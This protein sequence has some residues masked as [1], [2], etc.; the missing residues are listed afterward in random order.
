MKKNKLKIIISILCCATVFLGGVSTPLPGVSADNTK[1]LSLQQAQTMAQARSTAYKKIQNKIEMQQVKYTAAVKSIQMK[2][3]NMRTFRWTPLLSFKFPEQPHLVDEYEWQYK[4][5]QITCEIDRLRHS[6]QDTKLSVKETVSILYVDVYICQQ[7]I[8]FIENR[9]ENL[10]TTLKR[11]KARLAL[12][13]ATQSDIDKMT[14]SLDKLN[15]DLSLQMRTF[16]VKKTKLSKLIGTDVS[17]GYQFSAPFLD[18]DIPRTALQT[19]TD[20]TLERDQDYYEA[21]LNEQLALTSLN[22][23]EGFMYNQYGSKMYQIQGYINQARAGQE[24][25]G[26]A[27]KRQYNN[28]LNDVDSPWN[29]GIR[30]LF[31]KISKEW[32]KGGADGSR[33]VEDDPYALYTA[34][35]EYADAKKEKQST[36]DA[37]KDSIADGFETLVTAKN[38]Y[39]N[40]C[41]SNRILKQEIERAKQLNALGKYTYEELKDLQDEY[42]ENQINELELLAEY[43]RLLYSYDRQTCGGITAYLRGEN[44]YASASGGGES[45]IVGEDIEGAYYYIQSKIED[46]IFILG[47]S[48]P[49]DFPIEI[50]HFELYVNGVKIADKTAAD[51][52]IRHLTLDLDMV[53]K[54]EIYLY[55]EETL[56]DICEIDSSV[57]AAELEIVGGYS[58]IQP[59]YRTVAEFTYKTD[60]QA[61][62]T[63]IHFSKKDGE[64]IA[65]YQMTDAA[66]KPLYDSR[67]IALE[68]EFKY[69]SILTGDFG[70]LKVNFYDSGQ[71]L[72]Y[73]GI[74]D[75]TALAVIVPEVG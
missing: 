19:I 45:Y 3:K 75:E 60:E 38:A 54:A 12:G 10:E 68:E 53:E 22:M 11:N 46:N 51:D 23:M 40:M 61:G 74:L 65:Y 15:T 66:G 34:A 1:R 6:Q 67:L 27:F 42:D 73:T 37:L 58:I 52:T 35:L 20:Y 59:A 32:F 50:T 49:E 41:S 43:S 25:D 47:I 16:E 18:A 55:D 57:N 8:E 14:K 63:F 39:S 21:K 33:Y 17:V 28:L 69:L 30:I 72:L 29:G 13:Q 24:I 5:I 71:N 70:Q 62:V 64:K 56:Q 4:P 7:K 2:K 26:S 31:I 9:I 36:E 44:L 48:I